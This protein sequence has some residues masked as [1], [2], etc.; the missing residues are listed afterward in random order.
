[1]RALHLSRSERFT[2]HDLRGRFA[3]GCAEYLDAN[4]GVIELALSH[5]KRD[6]LVATYQAGKRAEQVAKLFEQWASFL[7]TLTQ[8]T[9]TKPDNVVLVNFNKR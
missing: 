6:R 3:S 9:S 7:Q 2:L 4:E 5:S 8:P 1:M